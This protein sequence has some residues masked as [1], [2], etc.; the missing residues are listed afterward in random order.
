VKLP[1]DE[2]RIAVDI[3]TIRIRGGGEAGARPLRQAIY[4][5][6]SGENL[7]EYVPGHKELQRAIDTWGPATFK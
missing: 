5:A 2:N 6:K 4:V 7:Q 1:Q 3:Q